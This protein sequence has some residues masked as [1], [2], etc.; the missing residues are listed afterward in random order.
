[1]IDVEVLNSKE[2]KIA[3]YVKFKTIK[4]QV[5]TM[6]VN[7]LTQQTQEVESVVMVCPHCDNILTKFDANIP[8][9]AIYKAFSELVDTS[10]FIKYCPMCGTKLSYDKRIVS[11]Q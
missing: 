5:A 8:I 9:V 10:R 1:M 7:G 6:V 4:E 3:E 2:F 11:E